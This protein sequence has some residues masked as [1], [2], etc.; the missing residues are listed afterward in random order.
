M[1][2]TVESSDEE[3]EWGKLE[4]VSGAGGGDGDSK[5]SDF[6]FLN[7]QTESEVQ[8]TLQSQSEQKSFN[9]YLEHT[10]YNVNQE[11]SAGDRDDDGKP[12]TQEEYYNR[13]FIFDNVISFAIRG[14]KWNVPICDYFDILIP[15][16]PDGAF[17]KNM[18]NEPIISRQTGGSYY[19]DSALNPSIP[20]TFIGKNMYQDYSSLIK[21]YNTYKL[22]FTLY[23][24]SAFNQADNGITVTYDLSTV[25]ENTKTLKNFIN[26]LK[27]SHSTDI[28]VSPS[29]KTPQ[30][31]KFAA[32]GPAGST[33]RDV[34]QDEYLIKLSDPPPENN[35]PIIINQLNILKKI[36]GYDDSDVTIE[37]MNQELF[38]PGA[39]GQ[40]QI[41]F[42]EGFSSVSAQFSSPISLDFNSI[43]IYVKF[44]G[45]PVNVT[46]HPALVDLSSINRKLIEVYPT[47]ELTINNLS[48]KFN[49]DT[50]KIHDN[51]HIPHHIFF[52]VSVTTK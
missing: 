14:L 7:G 6:K 1:F 30:T 38:T 22:E 51:Y 47:N 33:R 12:V 36:F 37:K 42:Q 21:S 26:S 3:F 35:G 27:E 46:S 45:I 15:S 20:S 8:G 17:V 28:S 34:G 25:S 13:H 41:S 9:I 2:N 10:D 29:N 52:N 48:K 16:L 11:I 23:T 24:S 5:K 39:D 19:Q 49:I 50:S 43:K 32:D 31:I 40:S 4:G 44:Y 18:F